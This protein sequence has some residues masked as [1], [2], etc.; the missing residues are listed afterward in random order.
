LLAVIPSTSGSI[1]PRSLFRRRVRV[2]IASGWFV[3]LAY[4]QESRVSRDEEGAAGKSEHGFAVLFVSYN[5]PYPL[6]CAF[7]RIQF[8]H[9]HRLWR[10]HS[11]MMRA[12]S[13]HIHI[14]ISGYRYIDISLHWRLGWEGRDISTHPGNGRMNLPG[15]PTPRA[16]LHL[17][18]ETRR[19]G[20]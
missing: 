15:P 19:A 10:A 20:E 14:D 4:H 5:S 8:P 17:A 2:K 18:S 13:A 11:R 3:E 9:A 7:E 16:L 6:F 12:T 1:C